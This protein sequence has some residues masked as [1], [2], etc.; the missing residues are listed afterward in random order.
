MV[1]GVV[2][3]VRI[4]IFH[5]ENV[6]SLI[7]DFMTNRLTMKENIRMD[8]RAAYIK[9]NIMETREA[10]SEKI[11]MIENHIY[12]AMEGPKSAIDTVLWNIDRFKGALEETKSAMEHSIAH[13]DQAVDETLV[14]VKST[15]DLIG[16]V[17]QDPWIMVG[18]AI[19][20]GYVIGSLNRGDLFAMPQ[21]RTQVRGGCG[22]ESPASA[23]PVF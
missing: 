8:Q 2:I 20:M 1:S 21:A 5:T 23:S 3:I 10:M 22:P 9:Q 7:N 12:K 11:E 4:V 16:Q 6:R 17:K 14:R 15:A 19:L 18:S 13:I